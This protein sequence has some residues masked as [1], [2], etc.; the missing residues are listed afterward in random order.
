M[1]AERFL[2]TGAF[3]CVGA[4][5][6]HELLRDGVEVVAFDVGDDDF[7]IRYLVDDD[8]LAGV[9]HIRGD[10]T[11]LGAVRAA[12]RDYDISNVLHLAALQVPFCAAD[13]PG[14]AIVNVVGTINV[15][16]AVKGTRAALSPI[17]YSSSV[18][19]YD[20]IDD[21]L[22]NSRFPT[23]RPATHY[24]VYKFA[25][26]G[27][28]RVYA[29]DGLSSIGLRPY[30]V[31]GVGRDQGMTAGPTAAMLAAARG[32]SFQIGFGG[33][34]QMQ[35]APDV[36][37]A[38]VA[39]ARSGYTGAGVFN[40]GGPSVEIREVVEA[41]HRAAP[42]SAN[43]ISI[44]GEPL[45][46]PASLPSDGILELLGETATTPLDAGVAETIDRFRMLIAA[47]RIHS[48]RP[49]PDPVV[50]TDRP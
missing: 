4:W 47:D 5:A 22:A 17:V 20:A 40:L 29:R 6:V 48:G 21:P 15:F 3:G 31:Y 23:G 33:A 37:R 2:V 27:S 18:A 42:G 38:F 7:R 8:A 9:I 45:P 26:E 46:F 19:A 10:I 28:A 16:E 36:A 39:A 30:V 24:G 44:V 41:I 43:Q 35:Y 13:P 25:N 50:T 1:S 11:D 32:D 34:C 12:I 49:S 14:S